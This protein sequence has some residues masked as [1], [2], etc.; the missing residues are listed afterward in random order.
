MSLTAATAAPALAGPMRPIALR[1][2]V[3]L[4]ARPSSGAGSFDGCSVDRSINRALLLGS[5]QE[6]SN[7][8]ACDEPSTPDVR[9]LLL[10]LEECLGLGLKLMRR[11]CREGVLVSQP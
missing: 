10:P 5:Y 2:S 6:L 7:R 11:Q 9:E 3:S 8:G 1:R 4:S